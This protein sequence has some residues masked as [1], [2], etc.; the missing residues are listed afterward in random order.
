[1][2][3]EG[4][5]IVVNDIGVDDGVFRAEA[6]VAEIREAG[7]QAVASRH[8]ISTP[9]GARAAIA[10][11]AEAFGGVDILVNNAGLRAD[12]GVD[13]ITEDE[14][15]IVVNSHL[16]AS[17]LTIK[18]AVPEF[19]K[20]GRGLIIN[21]GSEA[22]L[23]MPFNAAYAAAKEGIAGLTRTVAREL[24]HEKIRC[25]MILPRATV[26]TGGGKWG[27]GKYTQRLP[28]LEALG[29]YWLGNRG[30]TL[31][32]NAPSMPDHVAEFVTW[33]CTDAALDVNGVTFFVGGEEIGIVSEPEVV[34]SIVRPGKWSIDE[35]DAFGRDLITGQF[36]RFLINVPKKAD[37]A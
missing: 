27:G 11:G 6:V 4:A 35:M 25:N 7:G 28:I 22:G 26:G 1:M 9:E 18:F 2:S 17:F 33:L 32:L 16:K 24:G 37:A 34:R 8:D 5:S 21:T 3:R 15:N 36:D 13:E 29:R 10:A 14:W 20:R 31:K 30:H 23:G 12:G 19:R